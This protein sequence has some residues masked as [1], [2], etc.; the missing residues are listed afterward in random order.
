MA[1]VAT[2]I[3]RWISRRQVLYMLAGKPS[4]SL[5]AHWR[6]SY[7]CAFV[8]SCFLTVSAVKLVR[9]LS[10]ALIVLTLPNIPITSFSLLRCKSQDILQEKFI[11]SFDQH[12]TWP[13]Q[14]PA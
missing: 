4:V 10:N 13:L 3:Q 2:G 6:W 9:Y 5:L 12:K 7:R 8:S 1:M 11:R 14:I